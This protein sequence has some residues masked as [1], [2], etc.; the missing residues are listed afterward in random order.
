MRP[1]PYPPPRHLPGLCS[2]AAA[3]TFLPSQTQSGGATGGETAP[4]AAPQPLPDIE[5]T[6]QQPELVWGW[7]KRHSPKFWNRVKKRWKGAGGSPGA[8]GSSLGE[9]QP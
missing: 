8:G 1:P 5:G 7:R 6:T 9:T 2:G 3:L 4:A